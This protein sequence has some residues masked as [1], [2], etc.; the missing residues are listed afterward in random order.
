[1]LF[2]PLFRFSVSC[3]P[4]RAKE[5]TASLNHSF[6]ASMGSGW[7]RGKGIKEMYEYYRLYWEERGW[8]SNNDLR[9]SLLLDFE[10][11]G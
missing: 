4:T 1:M 8:W 2:F 11:E 3:L 7:D 5:C 9:S 10:E 6:L